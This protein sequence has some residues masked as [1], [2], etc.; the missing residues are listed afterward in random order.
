MIPAEGGGM[1]IVMNISLLDCTLRDGGYL[2]EWRFGKNCIK[3]ILQ[4]LVLAKID[5]I[6]VGFI[7]ENVEEDADRTIFPD[8]LSINK[9]LSNVKKGA[10][11]F[12]AMIDYGT[13]SIDNIPPQNESLIDGIRVIFKKKNAEEAISFGCK[14]KEKGYLVSLQMVSITSYSDNDVLQFCK[15]VNQVIPFAVGIVDT[16]GLLHRNQAKKYFELLNE[17]LDKRINIGYHSHNNFQL[18]YSNTIE[19]VDNTCD[20]N[21]ILDGTAYGMGKSAGNAPL[22]LLAMYLNENENKNYN[23]EEIMELI[24]VWILPIYEKVKWGY[25][26]LY[27]LA[28]SNDCHP[29]YVN[30]LMDKKTLSIKSIN[31]IVNQIINEKKLL[32]DEKYIEKLYIDYQNRIVN[33]SKEIKKLTEIMSGKRILL[34]GPGYSISSERESLE[35]KIKLYNPLIIS[36][37][38][39]PKNY[40]IDFVFISNSKRYGYIENDIESLDDKSKVIITSNIE[41]IK[42]E[43][44]IILNIE[45]LFDE[46]SEIKDISTSLILNLMK[47]VKPQC[48]YLAG[49][50]GYSM[51]SDNQYCEDCSPFY[52]SN[53]N[54]TIINRLMA[55]KICDTM[56]TIKVEFWTE[57]IYKEIINE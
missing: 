31:Q 49:F 28:A 48:L 8:V 43:K 33:D 53:A 20:R 50:D 51:E 42:K 9:V 39:I 35:E 10:S 30:Y 56:K 41:P 54:R 47:I 2:N 36:I 5:I 12:F 32:Y 1:E 13:C 24:E 37:N 27:F 44:C 57:S 3:N 18:A 19:M 52:A 34:L 25:S 23:I 16:Y 55:Q 6:E 29:N 38:F 26:M 40:A 46:C 45:S 22:E 14:L 15:L 4:R 11:K 7:N 17:N 21:L